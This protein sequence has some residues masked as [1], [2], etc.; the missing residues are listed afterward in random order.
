M[1]QV[2]VGAV[3]AW[4]L[5]KPE[6]RRSEREEF[7]VRVSY[8]TVDELFSDF[9]RDIN[10]GGLFIATDQPEPAGTAVSMRFALPG[11]DRAVETRGRV[12]RVSD[13]A[14]SEPP[15]MGIEFDPLSDEAST[16]IDELIRS[17][18]AGL[19]GGPGV[20]A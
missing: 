19:A 12:V 15:G 13:G 20:G 9:T 1:A 8:A 10:E 4:E 11:S 6:R 18:R 14:G 16:G 7:V 5:P 3:A 2:S 17:M